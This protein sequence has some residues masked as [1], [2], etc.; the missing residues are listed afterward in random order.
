L[1]P[2]IFSCPLKEETSIALGNNHGEKGFKLPWGQPCPLGEK[3]LDTTIEI[4][5]LCY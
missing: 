1:F 5:F 2:R 3:M 4:W